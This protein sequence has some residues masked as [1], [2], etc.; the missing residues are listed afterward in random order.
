MSIHIASQIQI[1]TDTDTQI[2]IHTR[3]SKWREKKGDL[4]K[5][6]ALSSTERSNASHSHS[7]FT[8][9]SPLHAPGTGAV[10]FPLSLQLFQE[11]SSPHWAASLAQ[12]PQKGLGSCSA[13]EAKYSSRNTLAAG[14]HS[15]L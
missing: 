12:E 9:L 13:T 11:A 14:L 10:D 8:G 6:V 5:P 1:H 7:G 4:G 3:T 15:T 2:Y